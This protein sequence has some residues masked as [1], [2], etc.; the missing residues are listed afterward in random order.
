MDCFLYDNDFRHERTKT[1]Y[2]NLILQ[3]KVVPTKKKLLKYFRTCQLPSL[4][5]QTQKLA[6]KRIGPF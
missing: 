5:I 2:T 3:M 1:F 4:K 6:L